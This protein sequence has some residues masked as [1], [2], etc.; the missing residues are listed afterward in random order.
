MYSTDRL[1]S[2]YSLIKNNNG[3]GALSV[4]RR[5][6]RI[7]LTEVRYKSHLT[8]L[9]Q[10]KDV[11]RLPSILYSRPPI[12]HPKAW[13]IAEKTGWA[14]LRIL[15]GN[16]HNNLRNIATESTKLNEDFEQIL[17]ER[18]IEQGINNLT[19]DEKNDI[20]ERISSV[21]KSAKC[22][23]N[24]NLSRQE[25]KA[26]KDLRNDKEIMITKADKGNAVVIM[27]R[28][29]YQNHVEEMLKDKNTYK[30]ITD[31]RRN[32]TSK[33]ETDLQQILLKLKDTGYLTEN[34]YTKLK[35]FDSFPA[36]LY[37][38]PKIHKVP[39]VE[40]DEHFKIET[41]TDIPFRP[42][43]SSIGSPTYEVSKYLARILK[44]LYNENYTEQKIRRNFQLLSPTRKLINPDE[45]LVS[46]DVTCKSGSAN[47]KRRA[48]KHKSLDTTHQFNRRTDLQLIKVH[49]KQ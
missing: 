49:I 23:T 7:A 40:Q 48:S 14:Y 17:D 45:Q 35:P 15:I 4:A 31:K 26:L 6:E 27:N 13:E 46:F 1:N 12:D 22:P 16:C 21:I 41:G 19:I 11:K 32:P 9:H 20:R 42:I 39:L 28:T 8:Y 34:E 25:E 2:I 18:T 24:R 36:A 47:R 33:I 43:N 5:L 38:L 44:H 3:A 10:C 30:D 37:C 29:D